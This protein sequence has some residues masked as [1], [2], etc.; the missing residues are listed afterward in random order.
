[1]LDQQKKLD[2]DEEV[3]NQNLEDIHKQMVELQAQLSTAVAR[4]SRI[5]R[6]RNKV[7]ERSSELFRRGMEE[8]DK[9]DDVVPVLN[10]HESHIVDDLQFMGVPNDVDWASLGLGDEF[11]NASP[12]VPPQGQSSGG[13]VAGGEGSSSSA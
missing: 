7:K 11:T 13:T 12:L 1:M 6:I 3:A 2:A 10:S 5:R 8:L 9:E 4:L